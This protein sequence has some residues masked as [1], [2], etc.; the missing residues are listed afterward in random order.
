M[1]SANQVMRG[2]F[3]GF[4]RL[5]VLHYAARQPIHGTH[6]MHELGLRGYE[7][8]PGTLYPM[9]HELED[10]K[11]I[12]STYVLVAGKRR[13]CYRT[14]EAGVALLKKA[15]RKA[16]ELVNETTDDDIYAVESLT[17]RISYPDHLN[18][19]GMFVKWVTRERVLVD[20]VACPWLITRFI[21]S[22]AEFIFVPRETDPTAIVD[23][24]PFDMSGVELGHHGDKCSFDAF[25]EKYKL[26][27]PALAR[28]QEVVRDADGKGS[29]GNPLADAL[30]VIAE[31]Y[32]LISTD[33]HDNLEK[34]F[35]LYD[36]LYAYFQKHTTEHG[37]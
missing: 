5:N 30:R 14:T 9:L 26:S 18:E 28:L 20:R 32:S 22:E 11:L 25:V 6:L 24:I 3:L 29:K 12:E 31:G 15:R 1:D 10:A 36:A 33:D 4:V 2:L 23:G 27:D 37:E 7:L 8:G 19:E 35:V 13:R 21:D 34:Q 17:G 16:L